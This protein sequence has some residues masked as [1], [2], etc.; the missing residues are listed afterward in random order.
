MAH[1]PLDTRP[2]YTL[3]DAARVLHI[4]RGTLD[5]L[6]KNGAIATVPL[7][8]RRRVTAEELERVAREGAGG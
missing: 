7:G 4:S 5:R 3:D 1:N 2:P 6:I 8:K